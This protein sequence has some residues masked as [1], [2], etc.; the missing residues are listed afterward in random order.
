[1]RLTLKKNISV[2]K[3]IGHMLSDI[4]SKSSSLQALILVEMRKLREF[5]QKVD[6]LK[7]DL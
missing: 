7:F 3:T 4:S 5:L 2:V 1:M 6:L